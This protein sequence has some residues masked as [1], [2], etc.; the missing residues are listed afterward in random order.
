MDSI[1]QYIRHVYYFSSHKKMQDGCKKMNVAASK[2][3]NRIDGKH[4]RFCSVERSSPIVCQY[5]KS[6]GRPKSTGNPDTRKVL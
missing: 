2:V 5:C 4:K 6:T 3:A 1:I